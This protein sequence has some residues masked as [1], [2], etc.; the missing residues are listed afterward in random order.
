M[1]N[2]QSNATWDELLDVEPQTTRKVTTGKVVA[3]FGK[4]LLWMRVYIAGTF[5]DMPST[6]FP[7]GTTTGD[8]V[9]M[10]IHR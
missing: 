6:M 4:S 9:T 2:N 10:E 1:N 7:A 8:T 3:V 5:L